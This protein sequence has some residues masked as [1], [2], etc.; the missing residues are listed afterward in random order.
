[1]SWTDSSSGL[2]TMDEFVLALE[3]TLEF[4]QNSQHDGGLAVI[5]NAK[6]IV[7]KSLAGYRKDKAFSFRD[8]GK[9]RFL[10]LPTNELQE[11]SVLNGWGD[12]YMEIAKVVDSF[13]G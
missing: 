13:L 3:K 10:F 2:K 11:I 4:L 12:E 6:L 9:I 1:V 7:E 5:D 8:K